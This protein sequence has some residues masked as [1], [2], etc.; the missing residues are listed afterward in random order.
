[1]GWDKC[2]CT[3]LYFFKSSEGYKKSIILV[4]YCRSLGNIQMRKDMGKR[5]FAFLLLKYYCLYSV[6]KKK[7]DF[8][9]TVSESTGFGNST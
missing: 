7:K 2:I 5:L 8:E 4:N 9:T 3:G 6:K 1:M